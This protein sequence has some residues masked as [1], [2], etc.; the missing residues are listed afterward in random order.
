MPKGETSRPYSKGIKRWYKDTA[1]LAAKKE[2]ERELSAH[3]I[4]GA[5][6]DIRVRRRTRERVGGGFFSKWVG[7]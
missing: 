6:K 7:R 3:D 2:S 5:K 4:A 1:L